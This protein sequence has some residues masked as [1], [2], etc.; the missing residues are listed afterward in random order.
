MTTIKERVKA[1]A[2]LLDREEPG[3]EQRINLETLNLEESCCCVLGQLFQ[4][5]STGVARLDLDLEAEFSLGFYR[6]DPA[7]DREYS[8]DSLTRA[9]KALIRE[10]RRQAAARPAE[11]TGER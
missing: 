8:W 11:G 7:S 6:F 5:Y 1:G 3:W 2:A 4:G 9:W 10:R